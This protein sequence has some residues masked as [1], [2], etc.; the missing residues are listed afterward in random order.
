LL[1]PRAHP[2]L[3]A[4]TRRARPPCASCLSGR[5]KPGVA[6]DGVVVVLC[7]VPALTLTAGI[8]WLRAPHVTSAC[9]NRFRCFVVTFQVFHADIAK[10][11][12][13]AAYVTIIVHV[14][15]KCLFPMFHLFFSD[16]C[17]KCIYL[18]VAYVSHICCKSILSA[19]CICL[20]CFCMC[21]RRMF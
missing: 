4:P 11:D 3:L 2:T 6:S 1:L 14:C 17:C 13:D 20:Q 15:C 19:Y 8:A 16:V 21:F 18:D 10:V 9:F 5:A 7:A 12:R